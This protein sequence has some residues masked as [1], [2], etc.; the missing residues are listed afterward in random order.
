MGSSNNGSLRNHEALDTLY[1]SLDR[2][3]ANREAYTYTGQS[4]TGNQR[5]HSVVT[6]TRIRKRDLQRVRDSRTCEL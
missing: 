2:A 5:V 3:Q 4:E 1:N 6:G